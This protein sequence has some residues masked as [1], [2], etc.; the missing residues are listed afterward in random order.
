MRSSR[1]PSDLI[2]RMKKPHQG[3]VTGLGS[4]PAGAKAL[5]RD[6]ALAN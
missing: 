5:V 1:A 3:Q 2:L 6:G 4:D